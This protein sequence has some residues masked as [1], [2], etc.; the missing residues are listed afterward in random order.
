MEELQKLIEK[1]TDITLADTDEYDEWVPKG[2]TA[3]LTA[4]LHRGECSIQDY[5]DLHGLIEDEAEAELLVFIEDSR[6]AGLSCIKIIHG[7]G[8]RSPGEPVLKNMVKRLLRGALSKHVR[9][10]ASAPQRDGG[11]GATYVLLRGR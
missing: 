3:S 8:L 4:R 6:N 2:G 7:R 9:A 1:K 11:L 10:Y 5:I